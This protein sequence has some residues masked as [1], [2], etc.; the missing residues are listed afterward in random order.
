MGKMKSADKRDGTNLYQSVLAYLI[1]NRNSKTA[2]ARLFVH[3]NTLVY[4]IDKA[5]DLFKFDLD[6]FLT[7][8]YI[9]ALAHL[10]AL[11][12]N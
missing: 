9:L 2:A 4:R 5:Q 10:S 8:E 7:C 6:S 1:C 3:R 11:I 12:E